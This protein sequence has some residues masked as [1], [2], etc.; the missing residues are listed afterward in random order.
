MTRS[1]RAGTRV[2]A[3][4][5]AGLACF[6]GPFTRANPTDSRS[7]Y[8][9]AIVGLPD[10]ITVQ[11]RRYPVRV[12]F[13]PT[14]PDVYRV[15]WSSSHF[16]LRFTPEG[17]FFGVDLPTGPSAARV[18][19]SLGDRRLFR[20]VLLMALVDTI[21]ATCAA[22]RCDTV[23]SLSRSIDVHV[24]AVDAG[25]TEVRD[26]GYAFVH[27]G[28][29]ALRTPGVLVADYGPPG[30]H[31]YD[32]QDNG[33]TWIVYRADRGADSIRVVVRQYAAG[34]TLRCAPVVG[35][36]S[37]TTHGV[38]SISDSTGRAYRLPPP[39]LRWTPGEEVP[40]PGGLVGAQ[41]TVTPDGTITG[42]APGVWRTYAHVPE[43]GD[44][45]VGACD[46]T[47]L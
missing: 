41:A 2:L 26:P 4:T 18:T 31:R 29:I 11:E 9:A 35:V 30:L 15:V 25:G 12:E 38:L 17:E 44:R 3:L 21:T 24:R 20:D 7:P 19:A 27:R 37:S 1:P 46:T 40:G 5:V 22:A 32:V 14:V 45:Q 34:W 33:A 43:Q 36:G 47:I 13:D 39:E 23:R 8:T 6:E 16:R 28:E 10:S 42:V